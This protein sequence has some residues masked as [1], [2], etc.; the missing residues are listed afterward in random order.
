[1]NFIFSPDKGI[2][3][4]IKRVAASLFILISIVTHSFHTSRLCSSLL[5]SKYF[6]IK[7]FFL[8]TFFIYFLFFF[9][10]ILTIK[11]ESINKKFILLVSLTAFFIFLSGISQYYSFASTELTWSEIKNT[12]YLKNKNAVVYSAYTLF[13]NLI[14]IY[15]FIS[16]KIH[17]TLF[18][19]I[20]D[21]LN[22]TKSYLKIALDKHKE[23]EIRYFNEIVFERKTS[24]KSQ[25]KIMNGIHHELGNKIPSVYSDLNSLKRFLSNK[26]PEILNERIRKPVGQEDIKKIDSGNDLV[27]RMGHQLDYSL[28]I[29]RELGVILKCD[30]AKMS[31]KDV[32]IL[33]FII[34]VCQKYNFNSRNVEL[35]YK[36]AQDIILPIDE[37]Q[38]NILIENFLNNALRHGFIENKNYFILFEV[39]VADYYVKINIINNGTELP[40]GLRIE[41]FVTPA[42]FLG[43]TGNTGYGGYI[44]NTIINNHNGTISIVDFK[45]LNPE[46]KVAFQ[47]NL[48]L[49]TNNH[50]TSHQSI[51]D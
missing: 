12:I 46:F 28:N 43:K 48:P 17:K 24:I 18:L 25:L 47:I 34:G 5:S 51:T 7:Y 29:M 13:V 40:E 35:L 8:A 19:N 14:I 30:P 16:F 20:E 31:F 2:N 49:K 33:D 10:Y 50:E 36:S 11:K 1:M 41:E 23:S 3:Y 9:T 37:T 6:Y 42:K 39:I 22:R 38:F 32:N 15:M 27:N 21:E 4:W 44:I 26:Y 45:H